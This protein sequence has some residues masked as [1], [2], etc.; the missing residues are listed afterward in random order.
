MRT[1]ITHSPKTIYFR[2][3]TIMDSHKMIS[4][5]EA[6]WNCNGDLIVPVI[7]KTK[8]ESESALTHSNQSNYK[9]NHIN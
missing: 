8:F 9:S 3:L 6:V 2:P 5:N 1:R 7:P 4:N